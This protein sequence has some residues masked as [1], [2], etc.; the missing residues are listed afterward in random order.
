MC[1]DKSSAYDF[2]DPFRPYDLREEYSLPKHSSHS[3]D[4]SGG[5]RVIRYHVVWKHHTRDDGSGTNRQRAVGMAF[6]PCREDDGVTERYAPLWIFVDI[7]DDAP[8]PV[9]LY[10]HEAM[11]AFL[12]S[13]IDD[14]A[15]ERAFRCRLARIT[16]ARKPK[17]LV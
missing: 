5:I 15:R 11:E 7:R 16:H 1:G 14:I 2:L 13:E 4:V 17:Q 12:W 9:D 6:R 3:E 8:I 10:R